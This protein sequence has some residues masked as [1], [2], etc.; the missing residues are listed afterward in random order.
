MLAGGLG[1]GEGAGTGSILGL[2]GI[3]GAG[4]DYGYYKALGDE[5]LGALKR[6]AARMA[7]QPAA[8]TP[9]GASSGA[10]GAAQAPGEGH[11]P[12]GGAV[13]SGREPVDWATDRP[14]IMA[15]GD[16]TRRQVSAAGSLAGNI[17][18]LV[19]MAVTAGA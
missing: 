4:G 5:S 15:E 10:S 12:V 2:F 9:A 1:G 18:K 11:A 7:A 19:A 3:G 17:A 8:G 6:L 13:T 14:D 16:R